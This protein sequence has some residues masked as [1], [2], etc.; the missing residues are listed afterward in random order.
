MKHTFT[1]VCF[2]IFILAA[3]KPETESKNGF[4]WSAADQKKF[5]DN[6]TPGAIQSLNEKEGTDYCDC[7]MKKLMQEYP[8]SIDVAKASQS[9]MSQ[10]AADCR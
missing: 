9:Q 6:C 3:C 10:W 2:V 5:M 4:E 1:A 7:V 8:N